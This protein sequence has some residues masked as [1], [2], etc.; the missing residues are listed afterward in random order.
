VTGRD[1]L[2]AGELRVARLA[3]EG[4]TNREVA[5]AL[6]ITTMTAKSHLSRIYRKLGITRRNQ[7]AQALAG[8]LGDAT[9]MPSATAPV[10]S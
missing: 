9:E 10:I 1:A 4:L 2:T 8:R 7:L 5:Q 3:A 6:F